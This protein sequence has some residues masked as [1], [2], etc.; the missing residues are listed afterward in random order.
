MR[1]FYTKISL[2]FFL[3]RCTTFYAIIIPS[4]LETHTQKKCARSVNN[5]FFVVSRGKFQ[6]TIFNLNFICLNASREEEEEEKREKI[7]LRK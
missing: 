3:Y 7:I 2:F 6:C 5:D 4:S 1:E